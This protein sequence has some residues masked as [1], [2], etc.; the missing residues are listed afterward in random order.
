MRELS[1]APDSVA[2]LPSRVHAIVLVSKLHKPALRAVAYA[3]RLDPRPWRHSPSRSTR[4]TPARAAATG[5]ITRC[6]SRSKTASPYREITRPVI[7]YVKALRSDHPRTVVIVYVPEYVVGHWYEQILHNQSALRLR[8]RLH[9][10]PGVMVASVP[11]Q[12]RSSEG[13][14]E[15]WYDAPAITTRAGNIAP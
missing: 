3:R 15:E 8:V 5:S 1:L 12:L 2:V 13:A 4:K 10:I 14:E 6:P 11:W 7:D 9:F